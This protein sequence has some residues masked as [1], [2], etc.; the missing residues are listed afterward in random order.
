[1][2]SSRLHRIKLA[3]RTLRETQWRD[4]RNASDRR[5]VDERAYRESALRP[6][7]ALYKF[8]MRLLSPDALEQLART[9]TREE[10]GWAELRASFSERQSAYPAHWDLPRIV[11]A[12]I[13]HCIIDFNDASVHSSASALRRALGHRDLELALR[14]HRVRL[15]AF[16]I[17]L[18]A[19]DDALFAGLSAAMPAP[20]DV[21]WVART[22]RLRASAFSGVPGEGPDPAALD[23]W[24][25]ALNEPFVAAGLEPWV[26]DRAAIAAGGSAYDAMHAPEV[27]ACATPVAEQP[28]VTVIVPTYN[29]DAGL[30][31]TIES[32]ARQSWQ[33]LE[34]L[35]VDDASS[36]GR[37]VID[38]AVAL[39]PRARL[40]RLDQ[41]GGAYNARNTGLTQGRGEFAT[42]VDA[43]DQSHPRR[44]ELQLSPLLADDGLVATDSMAI[45]V[46][47]DGSLITF[48][49][50]SLRANASSLL[51]RRERVLQALGPYDRV[52][53]AADTEY[54]LRM[55]LRFGK[56]AIRHLKPP[57]S[58]IQLTAGSLSRD[59]FR[60]GWWSGR[61]VAYRH[62]YLTWHHLALPG[63][64]ADFAVAPG[65][66]R[67]FTAPN[68]FLKRPEPERLRLAVLG[69]WAK[70]PEQ[71][72]G[73]S[74]ALEAL[75]DQQPGE[76][77][78]LLH[79][80]HPRRS[81]AERQFLLTKRMWQLVES[82]RAT[83]VSWDQP[84]EIDLLV[85]ADPEYLVL[86]PKAE[87]VGIRARRVVVL[88]ESALRDGVHPHAYLETAWL[89]RQCEER[90]GV[91][92]EWLPATE[93]IAERLAAAE[94]TETLPA[95]RL[96]VAPSAAPRPERG[97]RVRVGIALA[98]R[99]RV[100][101]QLAR[102]AKRA[103]RGA[104]VAVHGERRLR[105]VLR[106]LPGATRVFRE[107]AED[108]LSIEQFCDRVDVLVCDPLDERLALTTHQVLRAAARGTVVVMPESY[109]AEFSG[110][111]TTFAEG[112]LPDVLA[113]LAA[114]G[115]AAAEARQAAVERAHAS[116]A[117][118]ASPEAV[119]ATRARILLA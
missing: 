67:A 32:L 43:D 101:M 116:L 68:A 85:I 58:L 1:M 91:M 90:L 13:L 54:I 27:G 19:N 48:G 7:L 52:Y 42:V 70:N 28:L 118:Q 111:V 38:R 61:R 76:P 87:A 8:G 99:S 47:S 23:T 59:D 24:W 46:Y 79:G 97:E 63:P 98:E 15:F 11:T 112:K 44:I 20:D 55:R 84:T 2:T 4:V 41:N 92:P 9:G 40:I 100:A 73:W 88:V 64:D 35:V 89:A 80:I 105:S 93:G 50:T 110:I 103:A 21:E 75:A 60:N 25:E 12:A 26:L 117:A 30:L 106:T 71:P 65:G 36:T 119:A 95:G 109:A 10:L 51:F 94:A 102:R 3:V 83:W 96:R 31:N 39:D 56:K 16:Q 115:R 74:A 77:V 62:Q 33:N 45:R 81:P 57:M 66:S 108:R 114:S 5:T 22:D 113:T 69:D 29:P 104:E 6:P 14:D 18:Y 49:A 86:L 82:G 37:D 107:T 34:I 53:K 72:E 17:A 78:G